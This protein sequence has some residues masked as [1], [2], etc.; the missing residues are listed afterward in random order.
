[1]LS[2]SVTIASRSIFVQCKECP[3]VL[4]TYFLRY[5][6]PKILKIQFLKEKE[7]SVSFI[8]QTGFNKRKSKI[9]H[10]KGLTNI[11]VEFCI[12]FT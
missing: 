8:K 5:R 9:I 6:P 1:M 3:E 11:K 12:T 10:H 7:S 2:F 4:S